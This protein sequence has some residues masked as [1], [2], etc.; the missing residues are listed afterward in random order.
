MKD[1]PALDY[2][3]KSQLTPQWDTIPDPAEWQNLKVVQKAG[4]IRTTK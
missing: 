3:D 2:S 1:P 4:T